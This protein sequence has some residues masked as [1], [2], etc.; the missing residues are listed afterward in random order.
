ML[1]LLALGAWACSDS[2]G[3]SEN[4]GPPVNSGGSGATGGVVGA[5]GVGNAPGTGGAL[6]G[7][8]VASGG[9]GQTVPPIVLGG[10]GG[11]P[12]EPQVCAAQAS[13]ATLRS[14][15]LAFAFDVSGSMGQMDYPWHDP[16]LK[17]EPVVAATEAFLEAPASAGLFASLT[18]FPEASDRTKCQADEYAAPDVPM[19]ELPSTAFRTEIDAITPQTSRDWIGGT[20]T[21]AVTEGTLEYLGG[22]A[23]TDPDAKFVY[24]LVTDGY[25]QGCDGNTIESVSAAVS[26]AAPTIPTYVVGV[27][28]PPLTEP[29]DPVTPGGLTEPPDT[30][31]DLN[32]IAVAGGTEQAFIIE[33]GDPEQTSSS[34]QAVIDGIRK[35]SVSCEI[36]IPPPPAGEEFDASEVNVTFTTGAG[37]DQ[38]LARDDTCEA[39]NTWR[40][41][42]PAAPSAIELCAA[43]CEGVQADPAA[44][45]QVEFGCATRAP[46]AW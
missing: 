13:E 5:A 19:T 8:P 6:G 11:A 23:A 40:Y 17:W 27:A 20:P 46:E 31:S 22:L 21:L 18:F 32:A 24:V 14:V 1:P 39:P 45:L 29:V 36:T 44:G 12:P 30:V 35:S 37:V 38:A 43:T 4:G 33:T 34:L 2:D 28:N 41:D 26:A 9:V 3:S 42:D 25:P 16:T 10:N 7:A 15:Y